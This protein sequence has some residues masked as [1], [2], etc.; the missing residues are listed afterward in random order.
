MLKKFS[1]LCPICRSIYYLFD[2]PVIEIRVEVKEA[3][4]KLHMDKFSVYI[5][6]R[7]SF[8]RGYFHSVFLALFI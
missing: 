2:A 7:F 6:V 3:N 4:I 5:F 1:F 8:A